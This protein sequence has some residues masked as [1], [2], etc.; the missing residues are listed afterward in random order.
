MQV[1]HGDSTNGD[2]EECF[3]LKLTPAARI[4]KNK[5]I[6]SSSGGEYNTAL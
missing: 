6:I 1:P 5:T 3:W 4:K 2:K